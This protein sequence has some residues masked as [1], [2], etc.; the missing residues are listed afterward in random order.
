[1]R[2][3]RKERPKSLAKD[4]LGAYL[5]YSKEK[6]IEELLDARNECIEEIEILMKQ[7]SKKLWRR[8]LRRKT[9]RGTQM[10]DILPR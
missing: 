1:M 10:N 4:N 7:M 6:R 3:N 9:R 8:G 5:D 2:S